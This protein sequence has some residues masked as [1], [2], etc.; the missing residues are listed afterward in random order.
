MRLFTATLQKMNEKEIINKIAEIAN[1]LTSAGGG[2]AYLVGGYLRDKILRRVCH[3]IDIVVEG[4]ALSL[5]KNVAK[6]LKIP[7]PVTYQRFGTAMIRMEK[8]TIEFATARKESYR[9][10]SRKPKV[11]PATLSEDLLRRDFTINCLARRLGEKEIIDSFGGRADLRAKIIRTPTNPAKTFY[12]DPLRMLRAV[13]FATKLKFQIEPKTKKA[14]I[15]NRERIGIVSTERIADEILLILDA[16]IPSRG[17]ELLKE[18]KLLEIVLPKIAALRDVNDP[19]CKDLF[20][21]TLI[22]LDNMARMKKDRTLRLA[23]LFHDIGKPKTAKYISGKGWTFYGHQ[24]L[25]AKMMKS[26]GF[27]L[28]LSASDTKKIGKIIA[29]HLHPH[30]LT[31][32]NVTERAIF[33]FLREV[34]KEWKGLLLLATSDVTSKNRRK[35][36]EARSRLLELENR[37]KE[38]NRRRRAARFKLALDG[39]QIMEILGIKPGPEVGRV[40]SEL[41]KAV[42]EERVKNS[43]RELKKYLKQ[44]GS[45]LNI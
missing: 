38:I 22:V 41:E 40:K 25:G 37:I 7:P 5:A 35:V 17:I 42:V 14:I 31:R 32:K 19:Q 43:K 44:K 23:A 33:R 13:R 45:G 16:K 39:H 18:F 11:S 3:D 26:V 28:K 30:W 20:A 1:P 24:Y 15:E 6:S 10:D 9:K 2:A 34:G 4:D 29:Y 36:E 27:R 12:D 8:T 21:H